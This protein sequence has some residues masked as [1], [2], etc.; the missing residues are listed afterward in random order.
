VNVTTPTRG[1]LCHRPASTPRR[2]IM[3]PTRGCA[4]ILGTTW[5]ARI[6]STQSCARKIL[7]AL[8]AK[9][10][11]TADRRKG[12]SRARDD[13]HRWARY[14]KWAR[15]NIAFNRLEN[16]GAHTAKR[17]E[18][19]Q[20]AV[21]YVSIIRHSEL[22]CTHWHNPGFFPGPVCRWGTDPLILVEAKCIANLYTCKSIEYFEQFSIRNVGNIVK[23]GGSV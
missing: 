4:S 1:Y 21:N 10:I 18:P 9:A 11:T 23:N 15:G 20:A 3:R 8:T 7:G 2:C 12:L 5:L 13:P 16:G 17:I 6:I 22:W 14:R 19:H